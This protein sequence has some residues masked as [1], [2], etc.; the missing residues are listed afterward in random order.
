MG[1]DLRKPRIHKIF[2][3]N[4]EKGISNYLINEEKFED[5]VIKTEVDNLWYTPS[6][7]VPPNPAELIESEAMGNF[8]IKAKKKLIIL[9]LIRL[10]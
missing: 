4:N 3:I 2:G 1:L 6:G 7:P 9:S 5:V 8:I 10:Q